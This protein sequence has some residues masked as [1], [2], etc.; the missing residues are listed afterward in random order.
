MMSF[1]LHLLRSHENLSFWV[2]G[3]V[4]QVIVVVLL[5]LGCGQNSLVNN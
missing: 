3:P 1:R 2:T 5:G 4:P